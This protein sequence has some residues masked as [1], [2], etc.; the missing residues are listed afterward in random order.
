MTFIY[1]N[2]FTT[3][4]V[5]VVSLTHEATKFVNTAGQPLMSFIISNKEKYR[6]EQSPIIKMRRN[7]NKVFNP[8]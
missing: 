7:P 1:G 3:A 6:K 8:I 5:V 2:Q 4:L